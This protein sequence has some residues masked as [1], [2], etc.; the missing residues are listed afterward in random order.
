MI[1]LFTE[2]SCSIF[3][4]KKKN[5]KRQQTIDRKVE[6]GKRQNRLLSLF[7]ERRKNSHLFQ[8]EKKK[9]KKGNNTLEMLVVFLS[10]QF[11]F[12]FFSSFSFFFIFFLQFTSVRKLNFKWVVNRCGGKLFPI[13]VLICTHARTHAHCLCLCVGCL[14][15]RM[16]TYASAYCSWSLGPRNSRSF[17]FPSFDKNLFHHSEWWKCEILCPIFSLQIV[18]VFASI[19]PSHFLKRFNLVFFLIAH[20]SLS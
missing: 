5:D 3:N 17:I 13:P 19:M 10:R 18:L 14:H 4:W 8:R 12:P 11:L 15:A 1:P 16:Y 20:S 9:Q 2:I 7:L 6:K